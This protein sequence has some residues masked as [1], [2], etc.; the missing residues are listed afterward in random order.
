MEKQSVTLKQLIRWLVIYL[1]NGT[2]QGFHNWGPVVRDFNIL[3][4]YMDNIQ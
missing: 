1:V 2:I 4:L 3:T